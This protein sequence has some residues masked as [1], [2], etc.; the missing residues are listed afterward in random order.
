MACPPPNEA[1]EAKLMDL[2][3]LEG[4]GGQE[5]TREEFAALLTAAGFR[6]TDVIPT[7]AMVSIV[8]AVPT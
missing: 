5:R 3:M 1:A 6:L 4:P 8:E 2:I 7:G